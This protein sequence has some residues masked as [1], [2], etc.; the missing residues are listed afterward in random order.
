[1]SPDDHDD[2]DDDEGQTSPLLMFL[3]T[4]LNHAFHHVIDDVSH[5]RDDA[6]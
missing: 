3:N 5:I 4:N 2:D 1:M 6:V